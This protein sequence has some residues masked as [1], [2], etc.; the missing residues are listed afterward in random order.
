MEEKKQQPEQAT[1]KPVQAQP[2]KV[3]PKGMMELPKAE[4][5]PKVE[6][7]LIKLWIYGKPYSGKSTFANQA[8][9]P[10]V[11]NTDGNAGNLD[12]PFIPLK[13]E[14]YMLGNIPKKK[15][16]W[17]TFKNAIATLEADAQ[18]FK[19]VVV[20]LVEGTYELCRSYMYKEHG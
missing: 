6:K 16:G 12:A 19:T 11:L 17:E 8:D 18:G 9:M 10:L 4:R 20:D 5:C 15:W 7:K 3:V 13:D 2:R 14:N 1:A